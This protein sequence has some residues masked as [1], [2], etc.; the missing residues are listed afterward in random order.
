MSD[1]PR[2]RVPFRRRREGRT[3]YRYRLRLLRSGQP[4]AVVRLTNRRVVVAVTAFDPKGDRIIASAESPELAR[5][6]FP[7]SGLASTP[8]SY[9][10]G[11]LAGLRAKGAGS[12]DAV[13][14]AGLRRPTTGGRLWGAVKGLVDAGVKIPHGEGRFPSADRLG[15]S[16]LVHPP[17]KLLES[18]R[19]DLASI[20][21]RPKG[22]K[23]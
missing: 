2:H 22:G 21:V 23:P 6:G 15:G 9:L 11:Y 19:G 5:I 14:D 10:T 13:L 17:G 12:T 8:A 7:K 16:H 3:D 4:R 1:G 20:V 18:F